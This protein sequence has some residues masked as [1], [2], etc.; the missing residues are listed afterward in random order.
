MYI[1]TYIIRIESVEP[2]S[3]VQEVEVEPKSNSEESAVIV[4]VGANDD[5]DMSGQIFVSQEV[6]SMVEVL[7]TDIMQMEVYIYIYIYIYLYV[8]KYI[9]FK[10]IYMYI[11]IH[12]YINLHIFIQEDKAIPT[13]STKLLKQKTFDTVLRRKKDLEKLKNINRIYSTG[14]N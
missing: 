8:Y 14:A 3:P 12:V 11:Y 4:H 5:V 7:V 10:Y 6:L 2:P 13:M 9:Y 1:C